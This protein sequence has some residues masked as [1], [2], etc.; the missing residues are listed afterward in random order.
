MEGPA[1]A[2]WRKLAR[3]IRWDERLPEEKSNAMFQFSLFLLMLFWANRLF[4]RSLVHDSY[5]SL[6]M[7]LVQGDWMRGVNLFAFCSILL[8]SGYAVM[9]NVASRFLL[10]LTSGFLMRKGQTICR[11]VESFIRYISLIVV[12]YLTLNYLGLPVGTVVG[13][14][15]IAS[16]A[17]SLGAKDLAADILA[18]LFI[19]FERTFQVGDVVEIN[20]KHGKVQEIGVRTTKLM[21]PGNNVQI[22]GNHCIEEVLNLTYKLSWC[23]VALRV[24][25]KESLQHIEEVLSRE[26]PEIGKRCDKIVG[27]INYVGVT[28]IGGDVGT[29]MGVP[30]RTLT[31]SA[32]CREEDKYSV[33]L[34]INREICLLFE[35]EEIELW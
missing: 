27:T 31:I 33:R 35:R 4:S 5:D 1:G 19:V 14:L 12:L 26:L 24:P 9:I 23:S 6:A 17:L 7:F 32:E 15:G 16:L 22:F 21:L 11:L 13:S 34:Y 29:Y 8:V 18:G 2:V 30:T 20:G 28:E 3:A 10:G 25:A